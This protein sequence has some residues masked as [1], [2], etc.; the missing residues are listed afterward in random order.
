[1][2]LGRWTKRTSQCPDSRVVPMFF[3]PAVSCYSHGGLSG[4]LR[5]DRR[6]IPLLSGVHS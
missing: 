2:F 6:F 4:L 5:E 1:M 3:R